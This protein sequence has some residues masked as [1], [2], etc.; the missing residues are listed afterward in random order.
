MRNPELG[1]PIRVVP[2]E[3][4]LNEGRQ[5]EWRKLGKRWDLGTAWI[6]RLAGEEEDGSKNYSILIFEPRCHFFISVPFATHFTYI[7]S[8]SLVLLL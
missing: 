3:E 8:F 1:K 7:I 6:M 2:G 4:G 5:L